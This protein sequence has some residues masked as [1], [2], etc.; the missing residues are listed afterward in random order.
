MYKA[1]KKIGIII[2][3]LVIGGFF[4]AKFYA[5]V[6]CVEHPASFTESFDSPTTYKDDSP[7]PPP[8]CS[9]SHWGEGYITLNRLGANFT[10]G[11][12]GNFPTWINTVASGDFDGD[13]WDE[14]V[15]SSS[16]FCNALAFIDNKT[17]G[18]VSKFG[19][20]YWIDGSNGPL[21][22]AAGDPTRGIKNAALDTQ[23]GHCT[24]TSGDYDNDGDIDF[25]YVVSSRQ[26][27]SAGQIKQ[28]WLYE[29]RRV[30]TGTMTF[31]LT[32]LTSSFASAVKGILW[33]ATAMQSTDMD[34]DGDID[35]VMGNRTGEVLLWR[36]QGTGVINSS[37]FVIEPPLITTG[38]GGVGA[39]TVTVGDMNK[40]GFKDIIV[41]SVTNAAL[42]YYQNDKTGHY[43]LFQTI[44]G[45]SA[46]TNKSDPLWNLYPGGGTVALVYDFN[47]DGFLEL[48]VGCDGAYGWKTSPWN[49]SPGGL[50]YYFKNSGGELESYCIYDNRPACWDFDLGALVDY[51]NDDVM[52][53]FI[54]DGNHTELY[55]LFKNGLADVYA[56][57]GTAVS[58]NVTPN[59]DP[60]STSITK[61]RVAM[62]QSVIGSSST[63]LS[64]KL[65][66]SNNDG[67]DWELYGTYS[68]SGIKNIADV[69][70]H[71]FEH[72]GSMLRW[73]AT[74]LATADP[75]L[76]AA[77][78][79]ASLETPRIDRI[80][81]EYVYVDI[82]EYSRSSTVATVNPDNSHEL[83][84]GATFFYPGWQGHL[85][86]YDV[87]TMAMRQ[88]AFTALQT[89]S[90]SDQSGGRIQ[91]NG[92]TLVWDAGEIL[93]NRSPDSRTIYTAIRANRSL[94][95]PLVLAN[96][97][98]SNVT[99]LAP[100]LQETN[101]KN[102]ELVEFVRGQDRYWR[103]GDID[104]SN[105]VVVG[106]PD[107]NS[108][109]MGQAGYSAH[110]DAMKNRTTVVYVGA[111]DG[112][113]HCFRVT[114]G[115][116]LWGFIPYNLLPRLKEMFIK[117]AYS[118]GY[119]LDRKPY[120][121]GTPAVAE[122]YF[123]SDSKWHT[124][125]ICGQGRGFGSTLASGGTAAKNFYFALDVTTPEAP[126]PLWEFTHISTKIISGRTYTYT[127]GE[128]WS[129]P[130]IAQVNL[131]AGP[132]WVAFMGSGYDNFNV[133]RTLA[134]NGFYA[135]Q[136]Q[137]TS[138]GG[139]NL[140]ATL[141]APF[142]FDDFDTSA[143][144]QPS[145]YR[146]T[147]IKN[148]IPGSPFVFD[149]NKDGNV[150]SVYFGDLDG[151]LYKMN[152]SN[153]N[154]A[155]WPTPP[156]IFTDKYHYPIITKPVVWMDTAAGSTSPK[157][158]FGTGGDDAA[159][160]DKYYSFIA[161]IDDGSANPLPEWYLGNT[162]YMPSGWPT[163][164]KTH[165]G[166]LGVGEKVWAD[167][168]LSDTIIYFST[169]VGSIES[170]VPSC[171]ALNDLGRL[172]GRYLQSLL[173]LA[174]GSAFKT[175]Q[176][177]IADSLGLISKARRAVT[178]G[179]RLGV[180]GTNKRSVYIQEYD[181]TVERLEQQVG[182]LLSIK[183]WRE[184]Y[185]IIR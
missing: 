117:N 91:P 7:G 156:A 32:N 115:E 137:P 100:F 158:F 48:M 161:L 109:L 120:V 8:A 155:T 79:E 63:G 129:V 77:Y 5:Q 174:G 70:Y 51:N 148:A 150:E 34:K 29:N 106:P 60:E 59:L 111:N 96:F 178:V 130:A 19:I 35:I 136:V 168:I 74:L 172:Y 170:V 98:A 27:A 183:S 28:I 99:A 92:A 93:N 31:V 3:I 64:V 62:D 50:A 68:G 75:E 134:G 87:T 13:G 169:L 142:V 126:A 140:Q 20:T 67:L 133:N 162:L 135:V 24:M 124:V 16:E 146:F 54:A 10:V 94:S 114:D 11:V 139:A 166:T 153:A 149:L 185:R 125:L 179:E 116:E 167:P 177:T 86:A 22:P 73:R 180:S 184:I 83:I 90:V 25:L 9:V 4:A 21:Y 147:N 128:T 80:K 46:T 104:H 127:L 131:Q 171:A 152:T 144:P 78:G 17:V 84:I 110:A 118:A 41:A 49:N 40:D 173:G 102:A 107:K 143:S 44:S 164:S 47:Q 119:H 132:T 159:P 182:A 71:T 89:V 160:S 122:V 43:F 61:V 165:V 12:A 112:M 52:D 85:R 55:Y 72:F 38:W 1:M 88:T 66:V 103:L 95:N 157:I 145:G 6:V 154:P 23:G 58:L 15:A 42:R 53:F 56:L 57:S 36:N 33:S 181:S 2:P 175:D 81:L 105:P 14:F 151:R 113:I 101:G 39:S 76:A 97:N 69:S 65:E 121:D 26:T 108:P 45:G 18:D 138:A 176:N 30:P 37:T 163:D 141:R 123:T 82:R